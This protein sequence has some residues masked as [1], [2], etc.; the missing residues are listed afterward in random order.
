MSPTL[1][2]CLQLLAIGI[3]L[4]GIIFALWKIHETLHM[5]LDTLNRRK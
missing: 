4:L 3:N 1:G 2:I 5:I